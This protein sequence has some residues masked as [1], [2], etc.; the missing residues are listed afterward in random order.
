[1]WE[2]DNRQTEDWNIYNLEINIVYK[3]HIPTRAR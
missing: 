2:M 1:M 3:H